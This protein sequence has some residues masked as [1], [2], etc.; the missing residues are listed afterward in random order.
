[1]SKQKVVYG[2]LPLLPTTMVFPSYSCKP[3][4]VFSGHVRKWTPAV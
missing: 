3:G 4:D 2:S 1:V